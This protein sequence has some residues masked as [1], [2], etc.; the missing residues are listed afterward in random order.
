MQSI[1]LYIHLVTVHSLL[2]LP[3]L[4]SVFV[5]TLHVLV[6]QEPQGIPGHRS[7]QDFGV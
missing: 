1:L 4:T 6:E 2:L 5:H 3:N 7:Q